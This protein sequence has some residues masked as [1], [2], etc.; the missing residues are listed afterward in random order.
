MN[1]TKR[2]PT[3]REKIFANNISNQDLIFKIYKELTH[4]NNKK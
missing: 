2:L 4:L 3:E 1:K